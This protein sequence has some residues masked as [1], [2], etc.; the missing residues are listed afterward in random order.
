MTVREIAE[1][2]TQEQ[3][4]FINVECG[5]E[6]T[7]ETYDEIFD[8]MADIEVEE[9][10]KDPDHDTPRCAMASDLVTILGDPRGALLGEWEDESDEQD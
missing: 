7:D 2:L 9:T 8:C 4:D 5:K 1:K 10:M 3:L 6:L